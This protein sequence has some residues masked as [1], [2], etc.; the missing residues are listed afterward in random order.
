MGQCSWAVVVIALLL[1]PLDRP[2]LAATTVGGIITS[3][4]H[5]QLAGSRYIAPS[6]L[7]VDSGAVLTIDPGVEVRSCKIIETLW[8]EMKR[9][10]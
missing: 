3:D 4:T 9:V 7:L 1:F 2:T 6:S 8:L 5:G 10:E